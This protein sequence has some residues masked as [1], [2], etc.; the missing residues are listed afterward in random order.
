MHKLSL[1]CFP[2]HCFSF[3]TTLSY[4]TDQLYQLQSHSDHYGLAE[5]VHRSNHLVVTIKQ[6]FHQTTLIL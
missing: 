3:A 5:V 4:H 2:K 6:G 1:I